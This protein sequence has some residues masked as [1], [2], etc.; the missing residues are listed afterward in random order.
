[1][2]GPAAGHAG[3]TATLVMALGLCSDIYKI[4]LTVVE[5]GVVDLMGGLCV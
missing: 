1:M 2:D 3:L 4:E 5:P